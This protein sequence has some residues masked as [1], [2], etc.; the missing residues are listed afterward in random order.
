MSI[1]GGDIDGVSIIVSGGS[2]HD[3]SAFTA[4]AVVNG[5]GNVSLFMIGKRGGTPNAALDNLLCDSAFAVTAAKS[6]KG[7]EL[8]GSKPYTLLLGGSIKFERS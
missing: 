5:L 8:M 4:E 6:G 7:K 2:H 1:R 3:K